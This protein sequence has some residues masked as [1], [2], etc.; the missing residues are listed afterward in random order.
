ME[1]RARSIDRVK[2]IA[3]IDALILMIVGCSA[4]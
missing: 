2:M 3:H 4:S 1:K